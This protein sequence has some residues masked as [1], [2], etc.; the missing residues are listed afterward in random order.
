M[1]HQLDLA[2]RILEEAHGRAQ[3]VACCTVLL[4]PWSM[5]SV[6]E[7]PSSYNGLRLSASTPTFL[8]QAAYRATDAVFDMLMAP[9]VNEF[10]ARVAGLQPV[11]RLFHRWYLCRGPVLGLWPAWLAERPPD[12]PDRLRICGWPMR[13]DAEGGFVRGDASLRQLPAELAAFVDACRDR[14]VPLLVVTMGTAPPP[15]A[16]AVFK[17]A[18]EAAGQAGAAV[19]LLCAPQVLPPG[20]RPSADA[21]HVAYAPFGALLQHAACILY[22]G[23]MGGFSQACRA[24]V[25]HLVVPVGFDQPHNGLEAERLGVGLRVDWR[26]GKGAASRLAAAITHLLSSPAV[27]ERC[28][29]LRAR[30]EDDDTSCRGC[31]SAAKHVLELARRRAA[32]AAAPAGAHEEREEAASV[33]AHEVGAEAS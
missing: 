20:W 5:R 22:N 24:G 4:A 9:Q 12:F 15:H 31:E 6:G 28:D 33:G 32:S 16:P 18:L 23:G 7:Q 2:V 13:D 14:G 26:S 25:P 11:E 27:R 19:A 10:R 17:A 3:P 1:G 8:K 21:V 29:A 30:C